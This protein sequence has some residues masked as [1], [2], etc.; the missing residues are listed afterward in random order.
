MPFIDS[1]GPEVVA[2]GGVVVDDVEDDFDPRVVQ[3]L[4]HLLE[5]LHL[6]ARWPSDEYSLC[7]AR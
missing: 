7:G 5:L 3:R 6:L 2:F 4:H 1:V